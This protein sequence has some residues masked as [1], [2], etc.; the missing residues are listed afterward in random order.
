MY[1]EDLLSRHNIASPRTNTELLLCNVLKLNRIQ[2]YLN[3][4]MPLSLSEINE[5]NEK[6]MRRIQGE[7]VQYITGSCEFYGLTI[8][9]NPSVLIPRPETEL[10]V[11]K[12]LEIIRNKNPEKPSVLDI[13]TGSGCIAIALAAS[14]ECSITA[15]DISDRA[16]ETAVLN[17]RENNVSDKI[18]F[19]VK[20]IMKDFENFSGYDIVLANPPYIACNE[21][22]NLQKEVKYEPSAALT[23]YSDGLEFYRKIFQIAGSTDNKCEIMLEMG[24]GKSDKVIKLT[25]EYF[26]SFSIYR[27]YMNIERIIHISL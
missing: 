19:L 13:G 16:I 9:V 18:N 12:T 4:D 22:N 5:F 24:D 14:C 11:D 20:D 27:D 26:G 3:H 15:I 8:N 10:I 25:K 7:P 1:A 6:L 17:S 21:L 2:L 23:D